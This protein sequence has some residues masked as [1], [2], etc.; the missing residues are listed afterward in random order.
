VPEEDVE[1]TMT[2]R[3]AAGQGS[4]IYLPDVQSL[5]NGPRFVIEQSTDQEGRYD[6][7]EVCQEANQTSSTKTKVVCLEV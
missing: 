7:A 4:E 5:L 2:V 3:N 6:A 1:E